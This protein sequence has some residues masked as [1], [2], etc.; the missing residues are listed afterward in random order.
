MNHY[1]TLRFVAPF[2]GVEQEEIW[3]SLEGTMQRVGDL[4]KMGGDV[5]VMCV[6]F[7]VDEE[8]QRDIEADNKAMLADMETD[9]Q[10]DMREVPLYHKE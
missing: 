3:Y 7:P 9:Y 6:A 1:F 4:L 2:T 5:K 10:A 8:Y